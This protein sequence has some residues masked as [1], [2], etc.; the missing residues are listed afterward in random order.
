MRPRLE[1]AG[2]DLTRV[3]FIEAVREADGRRGFDL[4]RDIAL[5]QQALAE[6]GDVVLII[7]DPITAYMG[8]ID[9]HRTSDVRAALAPLAALARDSRAA[10]IAVSHPSKSSSTEAM[11]KVTGS[12]AFVAAARAA[13]LIVKDKDDESR[14]LFLPIKNNLGVDDS[15]FAYSVESVDLGNGIVAPRVV[16]EDERVYVTADE[17]LSGPSGEDDGDGGSSALGEAAQFLREVLAEGPLP[18][19]VIFAMSEEAGIAKKT[20]RRAQERLQIKPKKAGYGGQWMW[21]LSAPK[22]PNSREDAQDES[23][24]TFEEDGPGPAE[25][26]ASS[27][28]CWR[29]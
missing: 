20:V 11:M 1:A 14:R 6:L 18:A 27:T 25:S 3:H 15:G 5:L 19:K 17:A 16:F 12:L 24:G 28:N 4:Q 21:D 29:D 2:A 23:M 8:R 7:I 22:M 9:T 13:Y 10:M 26:R